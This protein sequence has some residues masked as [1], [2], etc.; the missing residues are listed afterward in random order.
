MSQRGENRQQVFHQQASVHPTSIPPGPTPGAR[1]QC[2][3]HTRQSGGKGDL[4]EPLGTR[5]H[6]SHRGK[7]G[8]TFSVRTKVG[9]PMPRDRFD[10]RGFSPAHTLALLVL[11]AAFTA[12]N[13][14]ETTYDPLEDYEELI[15]STDVVPPET[16]AGD[17]TPATE[18]GEY[19]VQLL[20]CSTCHTDG[21]LIGEPNRARWL[22]GSG[23]GI[24]YSN[25]LRQPRPGIVY[26]PNLTPDDDTGLGQWS[27]EAIAE[28]IRSG[29]DRHSARPVSSSGVRFGG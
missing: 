14:A 27:D 8:G 10:F 19:L 12:A 21:A 13:A 26:P 4:G 9:C 18:R 24:A 16:T 20:G 5:T 25:P 6:A 2:W 23:V 17:S 28:A 11:L 7:M 15:P 1:R 22:A 3:L 29:D